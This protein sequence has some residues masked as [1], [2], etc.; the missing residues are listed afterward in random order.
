MWSEQAGSGV[1][2][3]VI[4]RVLKAVAPLCAGASL[5]GAGGGGF[6][7]LVTHKG[8]DMP[9]LQK[10]LDSVQDAHTFTLHDC[11]IDFKGMAAVFE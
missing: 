2:P 6:I 8:D 9:A 3:T 11:D 7:L 1:E 10:V 4:A 5:A